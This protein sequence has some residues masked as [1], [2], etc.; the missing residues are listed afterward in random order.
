[1]GV[2]PTTVMERSD[3]SRRGSI[4]RGARF[5]FKRYV[6]PLSPDEDDKRREYLLNII[7]LF[8]IA[9][10]VLFDSIVFYYSLRLGANYHGIPFGE[11]SVLTVFFLFLYAL[12]RRGFFAEASY[13]LVVAY[14]LSNSYAAYLWGI[15]LPAVLLGYVL[16]ILMSSILVG[17]KF[18]FLATAMVA[19]FIIPLRYLQIQGIIKLQSNWMQ[20]IRPSDAFEFVALFILVMVL[21]WLSNREI[22]KSLFRARRSEAELKEE[23]DRLEI[24]VEER[25]RELQKIQFEKIQQLYRFAEFGQL[26]SGLFHDILNLLNA[27]SLRIENQADEKEALSAQEPLREAFGTTKQVEQFIE[28]IRKQLDQRE[29]EE[30]FSLVDGMLQVIQLLSHKAKKEHVRVTLG[31][32]PEDPMI[33]F[34]NPFKFHQVVM[35]MLLNAIES[36][37]GLPADPKRERTVAITVS[38][39]NGEAVIRVEDHG[40]GI[41]EDIQ[42][43]IFEPFFTTKE[44]SRGI[45]IGLATVKKIVDEDLH[46][47]IALKSREG[48]GSIFV[49]A[50]PLVEG[51][52]LNAHASAVA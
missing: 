5:L 1:M 40:C 7:L 37:E 23:R 51:S 33:H 45:G 47:T 49:I 28:A 29:V 48:A 17:T 42:E 9:V 2:P 52:P 12:S 24:K 32:A 22:E 10:L 15:D 27:I 39:E 14:F 13:F 21:S 41:P 11:F 16:V 25:T 19:A 6:L 50:F 26:A 3:E 8:S 31:R 4:G 36:Y 46:G 34:G 30:R 18:G 35:N 20:N 38:R 44:R 43:K